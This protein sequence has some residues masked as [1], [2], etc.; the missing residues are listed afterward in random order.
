MMAVPLPIKQ[1]KKLLSESQKVCPVKTGHLKS[2]G[3][4]EV[5]ENEVIVEYTA[6]YAIDVHENPKS[7][8][9]KWLETTADNL[10]NELVQDYANDVSE[11]IKKSIR[12]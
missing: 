4:V 8:G 5:K 1:S 10:K 11:Y 3:K 7:K 12:R 2:T 6:D 9:Y